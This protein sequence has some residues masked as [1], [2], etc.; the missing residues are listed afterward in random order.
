MKRLVT[1]ALAGVF[2]LVGAQQS[3]AL[4]LSPETVGVCETGGTGPDGAALTTCGVPAAAQT[5]LYNQTA[6]S[7]EEGSFATSYTSVFNGDLSGG[8]I[9]WVV[10]QPSITCPQGYLLVKDGDADPGRYIFNIGTRNR[11]ETIF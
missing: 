9:T 2:M 10:G 7:G 4:T 6:P 1:G 8:S 3:Q 11:T 5:L